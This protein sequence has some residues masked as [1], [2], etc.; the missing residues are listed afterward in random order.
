MTN[1]FWYISLA[2]L[3][4]AIAVYTIYIK[5]NTYKVSTLIVYYLFSAGTAWVGEFI[6]LG[7]F[8]SYAYKTGLFSDPWAQNLL[9]H[10]II[11]TTL[12]PAIVIVMVAYS[13]RYGWISL[14]TVFFISMEYLFIKLGIY[15]H[16]WWEYYM[17]AI[18]IVVFL[19]IS[20]YWFTKINKK[21][22][23]FTRAFTFYFVAMIIVHM[24][25][26]ILLLL[27]KLYYKI[28][29]IDNIFDNLYLSSTIIIF[30]YHLIESL[31]LVV[32]VCIL[33]KWYWRIVP[34]LI[35]ILVQ[36]TFAKVNI[37]IF[38]DGWKLVYTLIIY[39]IFIAVF[40]LLEKYTLKPKLRHGNVRT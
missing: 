22:Y 9:G 40:V 30:F 29:F 38:E 15:E 8:N 27:G 31:L 2:V 34:F 26:P 24:P 35:S 36:S 19:L 13:L 37:L 32:F 1:L 4:V 23:G 10:L 39:D 3:S 21:R 25:A 33:K 6:I 18:T 16:H 11:N 28:G 20:K 14:V 5:I 12:Y 17:T 7:L